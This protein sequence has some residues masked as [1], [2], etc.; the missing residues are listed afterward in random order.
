MGEMTVSI[1]VD[2]VFGSLTQHGGGMC[3]MKERERIDNRTKHNKP[4][5]TVAG[6]WEN[7]SAAVKR[8]STNYI[9]HLKRLLYFWR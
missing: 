7:T 3:R 9:H 2:G 5:H 4:C 8:K 6:F 1:V